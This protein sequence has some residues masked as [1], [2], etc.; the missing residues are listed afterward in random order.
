MNTLT[1][2]FLLGAILFLLTI[3]AGW[4]IHDAYGQNWIIANQSTVTW[5]A[6]TTLS[7]GSAIPDGDVIEYKAYMNDVILDPLKLNPIEVGVV[8]VTQFTFTLTPE[9]RYLVGLQTVR[10]LSDSTVIG[11]SVIGWSD[12]AS[13][14]A[15][16][17]TFGLCC[18]L[19]PAPVSG[20]KPQGA[21]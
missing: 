4:C 17:Y 5:D 3:F 2:T 21:K 1:R 11:E 14:V 8:D 10:K 12:N 18:Y 19:T 13:I 9:N 20:L 16:G 6:V 7:D 15:D